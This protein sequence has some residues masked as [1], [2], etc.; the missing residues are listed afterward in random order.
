MAGDGEMVEGGKG[1]N[2]DGHINWIEYAA[3]IV[4]IALVVI[5]AL[6]WLGCQINE[7]FYQLARL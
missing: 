4:V 6:S 2:D 3:L 1:M 5:L 7:W